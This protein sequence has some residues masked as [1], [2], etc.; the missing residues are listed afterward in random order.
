MGRKQAGRRN[1]VYY[2]TARRVRDENEEDSKAN[3][4]FL[5]YLFHL[6]LKSNRLAGTLKGYL[7]FK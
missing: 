6:V 3:R 2:F 1:K 7:G 5:H 4:I